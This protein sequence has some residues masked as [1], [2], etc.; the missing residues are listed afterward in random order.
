MIGIFKHRIRLVYKN[1]H[2]PLRALIVGANLRKLQ[3]NSSFF[4]SEDKN[5]CS[6]NNKKIRNHECAKLHQ[7]GVCSIRG[8]VYEYK[9]D[10]KGC[11]FNYVGSTNRTI[12]IRAGEHIKDPKT[13]A[14]AKHMV[15]TGHKGS[16]DVLKKINQKQV[17]GLDCKL[18]SWEGFYQAKNLENGIDNRKLDTVFGCMHRKALKSKESIDWITK[19]KERFF[20]KFYE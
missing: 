12:M 14:I 20:P 18:C 5:L 6:C 17:G 16:F 2:Q 13:S 4:A 3:N 19:I 15:S 10:Q 11:N 1:T 8:V 9:C 7:N